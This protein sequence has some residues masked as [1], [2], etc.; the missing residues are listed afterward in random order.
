MKNITFCFTKNPEFAI[1]ILGSAAAKAGYIGSSQF[2]LLLYNDEYGPGREEEA[3]KKISMLLTVSNIVTVPIVILF[4]YAADRVK[5]W[6]VLTVCL[7]LC[8]LSY[9]WFS[10]LVGSI[11]FS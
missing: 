5:M 3:S 6:K 2:A 1:A 10:L 11:G 4:G 7:I 8:M 9:L